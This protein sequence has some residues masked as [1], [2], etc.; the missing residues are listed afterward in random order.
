MQPFDALTPRLVVEMATGDTD[1]GVSSVRGGVRMGGAGGSRVLR[2]NRRL[3][4]AKA[5]RRL[6]CDNRARERRAPT[7]DPR[8]ARDPDLTPGHIGEELHD[9]AILLGDSAARN[10]SL[11]E[12][13]C[14]SRRLHSSMRNPKNRT[15]RPRLEE[16]EPE[17]SPGTRLERY[18]ASLALQATEDEFYRA[19]LDS[20]ASV[21]R[22]IVNKF[23]AVTAAIASGSRIRASRIAG[24]LRSIHLPTSLTRL[25]CRARF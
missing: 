1:F 13:P 22:T 6:T 25:S 17:C 18:V 7:R 24:T 5:V 23:G 16:R 3:D 19:Q 21:A 10:D 15:H 12:S 9:K 8:Q 2:G 14:A 4:V 11:S 20:V